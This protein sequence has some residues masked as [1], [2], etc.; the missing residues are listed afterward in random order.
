[1]PKLAFMV[2]S[3]ELA[4]TSRATV[5]GAAAPPANKLPDANGVP[6][7]STL[8]CSATRQRPAHQDGPPPARASPAADAAS[9]AAARSVAERPGC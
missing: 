7:G 1:M 8:C 3:D 9:S 2:T 4:R 6:L 5:I